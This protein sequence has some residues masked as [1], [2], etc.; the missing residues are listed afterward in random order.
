MEFLCINS[1]EDYIEADK[2]T[3]TIS[4][5]YKFFSQFCPYCVLPL[6]E[7]IISF[8]AWCDGFYFVSI[9]LIFMTVCLLLYFYFVFP[10]RIDEKQS[11]KIM[12]DINLNKNVL[13]PK[14]VVLNESY[15]TVIGEEKKYKIKLENIGGVIEINQ[16]L[17]ILTKLKTVIFIVPINSFSSFLEK[18]KFIS[19][20]TS[21]VKK[22]GYKKSSSI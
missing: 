20:I 11:K 2:L 9:F 8:K 14:K 18:E 10:N 3:R 15:F 1:I 13:L 17:F 21:K 5:V 4:P 22:N 19:M 6:A 16:K 7:I 12:A